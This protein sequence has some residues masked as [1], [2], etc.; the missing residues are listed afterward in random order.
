MD[1]LLPLGWECDEKN[2]AWVTKDNQF[3]IQPA[4]TGD[5]SGTVFYFSQDKIIPNKGVYFT[6]KYTGNKESFT[7]GFDSINK[8]GERIAFGEG[9]FHSVAMQMMDDVASAHI[10]RDAWQGSNFFDGNLK[11]REDTWYEVA[12]GFDNNNNYIIKI[13]QPE[14]PTQQITYLKKWDDF[15]REYYFI[16]WVSAKR[17]LLIDDFTVFTFENFTQ[18]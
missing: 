10:I 15:P 9:G 17:S 6:F 12:L 16:S 11:L 3:K 4:N 2:A 1:G 7:L 8:Y 14:T 18:K 13:W 5:W